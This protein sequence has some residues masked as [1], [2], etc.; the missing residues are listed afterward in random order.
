MS[1][2]PASLTAVGPLRN[3]TEN[4]KKI[5]QELIE[6]NQ[7]IVD[8]NTFLMEYYKQ[9]GET[10][11]NSQKKVMSKISEIPQDSESMEAY[12]RIW[13]DMFENDF[14]QLFDTSSFSENY[15][16]LVSTEMQLLKRWNTIMDV[17][18]KS[19]NMPTKEEID[20]IYQELFKLKKQFK[21][22]DSS[23]KNRD[24]KNGA[25]K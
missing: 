21:K 13:I 25:T 12:K 22:I 9:L 18:L 14:T 4:I 10:W 8:F 7:E 6:A 2:K 17:M 5:S 15:N 24:R 11:T 23:K 16:K 20:E 1:S 19:A 3:F